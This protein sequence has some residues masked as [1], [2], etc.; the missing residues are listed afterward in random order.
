MLLSWPMSGQILCPSCSKHLDASS[1][2]RNRKLCSACKQSNRAVVVSS[3]YQNFLRNL[4]SQSKSANKKGR[5]G[6]LLEWSITPEDLIAL[7][8]K[9]E[10]R[11]ALSGM[12]LTHHRDGS[13]KKEYNASIDR[14]S[15][16]KEYSP[17]NVQLVC[18][19]VNL[20]K[21]NLPE[22][23]FYWWVKTIHDFSCD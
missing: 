2:D 11:C 15:P 21:H 13:G 8:E 12:Y 17:E 10:G 16:E 5:S 7:W 14:I 1:F 22:D 3:S 9:Q 19:R 6:R 20:L 4:H 18:Y 23:M